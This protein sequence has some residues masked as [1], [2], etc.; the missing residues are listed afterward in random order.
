MHSA[1]AHVYSKWRATNFHEIVKM[2]QGRPT[3]ADTTRLKREI[4][5]A[6]STV[7]DMS[8]VRASRPTGAKSTLIGNTA[9][10]LFRKATAKQDTLNMLRN[11]APSG[12]HKSFAKDTEG[13]DGRALTTEGSPKPPRVSIPRGNP[14]PDVL[15]SATGTPALAQRASG[16]DNLRTDT[17]TKQAGDSRAMA[18]SG[19]GTKAAVDRFNE[20]GL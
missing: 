14:T 6:D 16:L 5:T 3:R 10:A 12:T 15:P 8:R 1:S 11:G 9:E 2:P 19:R 7:R 4:R 13:F 17:V 18:S 20:K